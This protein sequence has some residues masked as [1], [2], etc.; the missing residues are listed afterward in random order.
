MNMKPS[1]FSD[2]I[3]SALFY[4]IPVADFVLWGE[5]RLPVDKAGS[6]H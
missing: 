5:N 2:G 6:E 4:M 1:I 3:H